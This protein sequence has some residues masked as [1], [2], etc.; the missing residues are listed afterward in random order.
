[1]AVEGTVVEKLIVE[2]RADYSKLTQ[3]IDKIKD[4]LKKT[5]SET[6]QTQKEFREGTKAA[7][8]FGNGLNSIVGKAARAAAAIFSVHKAVGY[9][10]N[11]IQ[12][13]MDVV[14]SDSLFE[15]TMGRWA[16]STRK[17]ADAM[18]HSL[19]VNAFE[20]RKNVGMWYTM[21]K[22]MG[23]T[24]EQALNM[25]KSL[26]Q[27]KYDLES[28]YNIEGERAESVIE[29]MIAGITAPA[30]QIG[31]VLTDEVAKRELLAEG[32]IKQGQAVDSTTMMYGRY[33]ALMKQT[34]T[35]HG[36]MARTIDSPA[37]QLRV[38]QSALRSASLEMGM[39]FL[40]IIQT[41][42]PWL[43]YLAAFIKIVANSLASLFGAKGRKSRTD[44]KQAELVTSLGG[45]SHG[46]AEGEE[47]W[48][49]YG[50]T[51]DVAL[52][53][54]RRGVKDLQAAIMGFDQIHKVEDKTL[55]EGGG[56]ALTPGGISGLDIGNLNADIDDVLGG[57]DQW[58]DK[59]TEIDE[60]VQSFIDALVNSPIGAFG[61]TIFD[62]F[63]NIYNDI[64]KP[65][66]SW[67]LENSEWTI[68]AL[69]GILTG[70]LGFKVVGAI[71]G[72]GSP[73]AIATGVIAGLAGAIDGF[74][75]E[76]NRLAKL[77]DLAGRFGDI[78][79]SI[80]QAQDWAKDFFYTFESELIDN[81]LTKLSTLKQEFSDWKGAF[82]GIMSKIY[83]ASVGYE[84]TESD[85]E[86]LRKGIDQVISEGKRIARESTMSIP[87]VFS[88]V[89]LP[90]EL[91]T[92]LFEGYSTL[93]KDF[94]R[95]GERLREAFDNAIADGVISEDEYDVIRKLQIEYQAMLRK[96]ADARS[97]AALEVIWGENL[98]FEET[99]E[100]FKKRQ[101]AANEEAKKLKEAAKELYIDQVAYINAVPNFS[102][103]EKDRFKELMQEHYDSFKIAV[104]LKN[105]SFETKSLSKIFEDAVTTISKGYDATKIEDLMAK[106]I[107]ITGSPGEKKKSFAEAFLGFDLSKDSYDYGKMHL[108]GLFDAL[109]IPFA[110]KQNLADFYNSLLP[111][112][113]DLMKLF[114]AGYKAGESMPKGVAA[115]LA[116]IHAVGA[117]SGNAESLLFMLGR[118]LSES[119]EAVEMYRKAKRSGEYVNEYY[120]A[121]MESG[122]ALPGKV[123]EETLRLVIEKLEDGTI[124]FQEAL[125]QLGLDVF[126][127]IE[128]NKPL[129]SL[130][131]SELAEVI[132]DSFTTNLPSEAPQELVDWLKSNEDAL[133]EKVAPFLEKGMSLADA[134][135][136]AYSKEF[137][138]DKKAIKAAKIWATENTASISN[139]QSTFA[140]VGK[141][142]AKTFL[143]NFTS[144][145]KANPLARI[146]ETVFGLP[147]SAKGGG[148]RKTGSGILRGFSGGGLPEVGEMFIAREAGPEFIGRMG[149]RTAVAN[150][151]QIV[152]GIE[153]GVFNAVVAAMGGT[154]RDSGNTYV[155]PVYVGG[156]KLYEVVFDRAKRESIRAGKPLME[157]V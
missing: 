152:A 30:K 20:V 53:K 41:V 80:E 111:S 118:K 112:N 151:D 130:S 29:G 138:E 44:S 147:S 95:T 8:I 77:D 121:G 75:R 91:S 150:N 86:D 32:I 103:K 9:L 66:G 142:S 16:D 114:K 136:A 115:G 22:S 82:D 60:Q 14:E 52:G 49:K 81:A 37:N 84:L 116:S 63:S 148:S 127:S 24:E 155:I 26:V 94:I 128:K 1:M 98:G 129:L 12:L 7:E 31:V 38:M 110:T 2:W 6:E 132:I 34:E 107:L 149:S 62:V 11:S 134:V 126:D 54:A 25:S 146:L 87:I 35:A 102:D 100:S 19:G 46:V 92:A 131:A 23:L 96:M 18:E 108:S 21:T 76:H 43:Q 71:A 88:N 59:T 140:N 145:L 39:A 15:T 125:K 90:T 17:W 5:R 78:S 93:E 55:P 123:T 47:G 56:N 67:L 122:M 48:K 36:D 120:A 143:S 50:N 73:V 64:L 117:A 68:G 42:L 28:F 99:P 153:A 40:P 58:L 97:V 141:T 85:I 104:D 144:Y 119:P 4:E 113:A 101:D 105:I 57:L 45:V 61:Q 79:I 135:I 83:V 74:F 137:S 70:V 156:E 13:A 139:N 124:D 65:L 3:D 69:E 89:K 10:K 27:L 106:K 157:G 33:L 72:P 51:A 133:Y 154:R 109:S